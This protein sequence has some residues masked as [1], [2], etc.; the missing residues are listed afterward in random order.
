MNDA[1][2]MG[3]DKSEYQKKQLRTLVLSTNVNDYDTGEPIVDGSISKTLNSSSNL[4]VENP[5]FAILH[6]LKLGRKYHHPT[7]PK[8]NVISGQISRL[9][10]KSEEIEQRQQRIQTICL[11][12]GLLQ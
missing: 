2:L 5:I 3:I 12:P 4:F 8:N 11:Y 7:M 9:Q 1:I 6:G 10:S